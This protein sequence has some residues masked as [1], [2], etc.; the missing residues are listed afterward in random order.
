MLPYTPKSLP[1]PDISWGKL[2]HLI[3]RA[4]RELASYEGVIALSQAGQGREAGVYAFT[5]LMKIV[6]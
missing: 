6:S 5:Q 4:N 2:T 1:M 3:A